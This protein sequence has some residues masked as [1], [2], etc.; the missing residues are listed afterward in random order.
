MYLG[1][2]ISKL[3]G[4]EKLEISLRLNY[5]WS[6]TL[7]GLAHGL[8]KLINLKSLKIIVEGDN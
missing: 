2:E 4:L 1:Y 6:N 3:E 7:V 5:L 8:K